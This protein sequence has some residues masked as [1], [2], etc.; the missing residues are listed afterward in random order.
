MGKKIRLSAAIIAKNEEKRIEST[1]KSVSTLV[2]R[3]YLMDFGSEDGTVSIAEKLGAKVYKTGWNCDFSEVRNQLLEKIEEEGET[4]LVLWIESGEMFDYRTAPD[5]REFVATTLERDTA[6]MMIVRKYWIAPELTL[7]HLIVAFLQD[8][9]DNML[10]PADGFS[11]WNEETIEARLIPVSPRVR[12]VGRLRETAIPALQTAGMRISAAS[13]R[14]LA[15]LRAL[16]HPERITDAEN[17]L[18]ILKHAEDSGLSLS[19]DEL[20]AKADALVNLSD[21]V[22]GRSIYKNLIKNAR[23][24]N[25]R[26]ESYYNYYA[27]F[28]VVPPIGN[29][30]VDLLVQSL[31]DFPLDLQLLTNLGITM[32]RQ[33]NN[34]MAVRV[35]EIAMR[36]GKI[37]LD[38]WH[39]QCV[40]EIVIAHLSLIYR[41]T[42]E[43]EKAIDLLESVVIATEPTHSQLGRLLIDLYVVGRA[44]EKLHEF[45][46]RY[47]GGAELDAIREVFTGACR[48]T[49]GAWKAALVSLENAYRSGCRDTYCLRWFSLCLLSNLR[50]AEACTILEEWLQVDPANL[51]AKTFRLAASQPDRFLDI[52]EMVQKYQGSKLG[53]GLTEN[54]DNLVF[55][56]EEPLPIVADSTPTFP[57]F[58]IFRFES[59]GSGN[60]T[61]LTFRVE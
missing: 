6:Y 10:S 1:I 2:D 46:A 61:E 37:S 35:F 15:A 16:K 45:A 20:F 27:T 47:W 58:D 13:G 50:F 57:G 22:A 9:S 42:G 53:I 38:V 51:E 59:P 32:F 8:G 30:A 26:L 55:P 49:G 34:E 44:E 19:E 5:F 25:L 41:I 24:S 17:H 39:K 40:R 21:V 3:V 12:F 14:V 43:Q 54:F 11:D 23:Q 31:D 36:H 60:S 28:D 56:E 33:K 29:E 4:D 7:P 48:A 52:L 18:K